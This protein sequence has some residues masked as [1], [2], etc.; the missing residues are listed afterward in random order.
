MTTSS[1]ITLRRTPRGVT[2]RATGAAA[3]ALSD[4]ITHGAESAQAD[5]ALTAARILPLQIMV[6]GRNNTYEAHA[7]P[8]AAATSAGLNGVR[9]TCT[10]GRRQALDALLAKATPPRR[11]ARL[12]EQHVG[13]GCRDTYTI[14][15]EIL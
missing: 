11:L 12:V 4:A 9:A 5:P 14:D 13:P 10:A 6:V 8:G 3:Q 7:L 15:A 2:I 1:R